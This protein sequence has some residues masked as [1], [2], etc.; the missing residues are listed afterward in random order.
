VLANVGVREAR[1]LVT[2]KLDAANFQNGLLLKSKSLDTTGLPAGD[3]VLA[4]QL[5]SPQG[6]VIAS[7]N[8]RF[9]IVVGPPTAEVYF[10]TEPEAL[11]SPGLVDYMRGLSAIAQGENAA[12]G[13]YLERA[14]KLNPANSFGKQYLVQAYYRQRRYAAVKDLYGRSTMK[15]FA[16]SPEVLAQ[17]ALSLWDSGDQ[18]QARTVLKSARGLFPQDAMLAATDKLLSQASN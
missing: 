14:L 1:T 17:I 2:E 6:P 16:V 3:Y 13:N 18:N 4:V 12:A 10:V 5:K 8:Q 9:R 7:L 11:A 15:D